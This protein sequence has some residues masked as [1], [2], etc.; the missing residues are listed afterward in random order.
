MEL[1]YNGTQ[2]VTSRDNEQTSSDIFNGATVYLLQ[3]CLYVLL[4]YLF[5]NINSSGIRCGPPPKIAH[6]NVTTGPNSDGTTTLATYRCFSGY[7]I[8]DFKDGLK[9]NDPT[10]V[11]SCGE[12]QR[13]QKLHTPKCGKCL[14]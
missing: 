4:I 12:E 14:I 1:K 3:I 13:W 9:F 11:M 6:G 2:L 5:F 10:F 8:L 7:A